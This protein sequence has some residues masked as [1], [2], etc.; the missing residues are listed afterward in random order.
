V[1][2]T[3][4]PGFFEKRSRIRKI[5]NSLARD[6]VTHTC[7]ISSYITENRNNHRS[8]TLGEPA[9]RWQEGRVMPGCD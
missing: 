8:G 1:Y 6:W 9:A 2:L 5:K 4:K 3:W 7:S